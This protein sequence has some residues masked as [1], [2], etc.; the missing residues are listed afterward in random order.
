[1]TFTYNFEDLEITLGEG[2]EFSCTG[3][4]EFEYEAGEPDEPWGYWGATP[5]CASSAS[6]IECIDLDAVTWDAQDKE[7]KPT[8]KE[9]KELKE[10]VEVYFLDNQEILTEDVEKYANDHY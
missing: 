2:F 5:G 3:E 6:G 4:V 1:M 10:S 9:L 7:V 8:E